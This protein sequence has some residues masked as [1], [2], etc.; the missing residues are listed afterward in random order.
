MTDTYQN[1]PIFETMNSWSQF[2]MLN[3]RLA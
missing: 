2:G 3:S 1:P